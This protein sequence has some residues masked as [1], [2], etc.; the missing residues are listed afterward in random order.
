MTI[1]LAALGSLSSILAPVFLVIL[2]GY[3]IGRSG[4]L[5]ADQLRGFGRFILAVALPM[6]IF[7]AVS[8]ARIGEV[9]RLDYLLVY[10]A[11]SLSTFALSFAWFRWGTAA[12][13]SVARL[14]KAAVRAMGTAISNT[15]LIGFAILSQIF[16]HAAAGPVVLNML[17][18]TFMMLPIL[19][20]LIELGQGDHAHLGA[21]LGGVARNL[22][23]S[24]MIWSIVLGAI[25][26]ALGLALPQPVTRS[27]QMVGS[28]AAPLALI[29]I[30]ATLAGVR[31]AGQGGAIV[32]MAAGK[33]L[34]HPAMVLL[35]LTLMPVRDPMFHSAI[36]LLAAMPTFSTL[37]VFAQS[38]GDSETCSAAMLVATAASFVTL[39]VAM[40]L[41]GVHL[42]A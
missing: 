42:P 11:A 31:L 19:M 36:I 6:L 22:V 8:S 21:A 33:L 2:L 4:L 39:L 12:G 38:A 18:E 9:F 28:I 25:F 37:T 20:A 24:S 1:D 3:G 13:G 14:D 10:A 30:G 26:A 5:G 27:V 17:V 15:A 29:T 41:L 32:V 7:G 16:G 40:A 23:R 35:F 34:L